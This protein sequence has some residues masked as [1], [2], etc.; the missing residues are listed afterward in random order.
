VGFLEFLLLCNPRPRA[1]RT[2][3]RRRAPAAARY[4]TD[5]KM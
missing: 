4:K 5:P 1:A 2:P 3:R